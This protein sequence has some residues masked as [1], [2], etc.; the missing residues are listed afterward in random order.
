MSCR[1]LFVSDLH[2]SPSRYRT[3]WQVAAAEA[4]AAVLLGGDLLPGFV[5]LGGEQRFIA[6]ELETPVR[7]L[8]K[9]LGERCPTILVI[10]GNDDPAASFA[11]L[12]RGQDEGLWRLVHHRT[13]GV[14]RHT[15][16]GYACVPPT[17]F[18]LKDWE[19][20]DVSRF[21]DPG[22]IAPEEGQHTRSFAPDDLRFGTI[23]ADLAALAEGTDQENAVWLFHTPPYQTPLDRADLDGRFVDHAPVDVHVGSIAVRRFIEDRQPLV[24][25]H[26]HV[27][28]APRLT[29]TW[30]ERLGRTWLLTAAHD[31]PELA[32][33]RL[34]LDDPG[35]ATREL[36]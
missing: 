9:R 19:R 22:C 12:E 35:G 14:G 13:V 8:H 32:L 27:H 4:P 10:P 6:D 15:V 1:C 2:G 18:L 20:Y 33:V 25:L 5:G 3:L 11:A 23:A 29:G 28:E 36:V 34:D 26:G 16:S 31:G 24:T 30:K 21:V 17:P 7:H